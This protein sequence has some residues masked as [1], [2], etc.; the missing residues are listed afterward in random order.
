M[1]KIIFWTMLFLIF[2]TY[3][4]YPI[5]LLILS[6]FKKKKIS[7]DK[8]YRP[9]VSLIIVAHNEEK[10]IADRLDNALELEYPK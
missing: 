3:I 10:V 6:K 9:T 5:F 2:Y 4:G 7:Y 8:N 1:L